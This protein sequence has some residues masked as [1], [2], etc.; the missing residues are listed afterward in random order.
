MTAEEAYEYLLELQEAESSSDE[1]AEE[2]SEIILQA[3][4]PDAAS[5]ED[6]GEEDGAGN[7]GNLPR[8]QLIA[9]C[10]VVLKRKNR[11]RTTTV[12]PDEEIAIDDEQLQFH[13]EDVMNYS[14]QNINVDLLRSN[15]ATP[16]VSIFGSP[17]KIVPIPPSAFYE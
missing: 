17:V 10:E 1:E 14:F 12:E 6:S 3:P 9:P 4:A 15:A 11:P 16:S 13:L 2:V 8:A 7:F 5:D